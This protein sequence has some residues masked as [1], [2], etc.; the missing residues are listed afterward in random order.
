MKLSNIVRIILGIVYFIGALINLRFA[1]QS[2]EVYQTFADFAVI[3]FYRTLWSSI[4]MPHITKW[5]LLVVGCEI[6]MGLFILSKETLVKIGLLGGIVFN[7]MLIPFWWSGWGVINLFIVLIQILL[8]RRD[9][10]SS[11]IGLFG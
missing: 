4:V 1:L 9:Y 10:D 11:I 7:L 6:I 2:P 5:L 8:L 3:P